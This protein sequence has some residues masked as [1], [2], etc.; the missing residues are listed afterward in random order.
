MGLGSGGE[1]E[2]DVLLISCDVV[3]TMPLRGR[4]AIVPELRGKR[5]H[6]D[7]LNSGR[8]RAYVGEASVSQEGRGMGTRSRSR[9]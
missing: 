7:P 2:G 3:V 9:M 8:S 4:V 1:F 5:G 6:I